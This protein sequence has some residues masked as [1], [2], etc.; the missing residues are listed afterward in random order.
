LVERD[1]QPHLI[2]FF[3]DATI[4]KGS[5]VE[6]SESAAHHARVRRVRVGDGVRLTDGRGNIGLGSIVAI[7]RQTVGVAVAEESM[8]PRPSVVHVRAPIG[9]RDRMLWLTEKATELG[10]TSWQAVRF[11]RSASVSPRGEG[12]AFAAKVRARMIAALEQ[13][14]GAWLPNVLA[15]SALG[16]IDVTGGEPCILLDRDGPPLASLLG[17]SSS[18]EPVILLGPEGGLEAGEVGA[19]TGAGWQRASLADTTLRFETAGIAA[20]AVCRALLTQSRTRGVTNG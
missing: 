19:L 11:A 6:L 13:S 2:T 20:I 8:V 16:S 14:G 10:I 17:L 1:R 15:D 9:D 4:V 18:A 12:A 7:G 5:T 3:T